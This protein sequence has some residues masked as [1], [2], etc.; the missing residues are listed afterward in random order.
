M[1]I[2]I[3]LTILTVVVSSI[4][5]YSKHKYS[6]WK[7]HNIPYIEPRLPFGNIQ[8][9]GRTIH[10]S[11]LTHKFYKEL[12][13]KGAFAGIYLFTN[14]VILALDLEFV[15]TILIKDFNY[16]QDRGLYL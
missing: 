11:Q 13:G 10:S 8:G 12:K 15:K 3:L 4:Y 1:S 16:F 2:M 7:R 5:F 6:Y 14:P 9:V